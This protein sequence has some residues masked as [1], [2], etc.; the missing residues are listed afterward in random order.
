MTFSSWVWDSAGIDYY[1]FSRDVLFESFVESEEWNV[2]SFSWNR[3]E[4]LYKCCPIPYTLLH[5]HLVIKRKA[6]YYVTNLVVPTGIITLVAVIGFFSP[7]ASNGDRTEKVNLGITTLLAMSIQLLMISDKMPTTSDS[8]PLMEW[9]FLSIIVITSAGT[10]M[11]S[12]IIVIHQQYLYGKRV[13][14][15]VRNVF[16]RIIG[17]IVLVTPTKELEY[18]YRRY[19]TGVTDF[20]AAPL[21]PHKRSSIRSKKSLKLRLSR[22]GSW[23][24]EEELMRGGGE[25]ASP[26]N[27]PRSLRQSTVREWSG[28]TA[29]GD[30]LP[31][32]RKTASSVNLEARETIAMSAVAMGLAQELRG[33][34]DAIRNAICNED[35]QLIELEWSYLAVILDRILL[36]IFASTVSIIT[37]AMM[38]A[39]RIFY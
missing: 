23:E 2:V 37:L 33:S 32:Q 29:N 6:L 13:P 11:T 3:E 4:V 8:V 31:P 14:I 28:G 36:V 35:R 20:N 24:T 10:I 21:P 18:R 34:L 5:A 25:A 27:A 26:P 22:L 1:P 17:P 30:L 9:F 39:E 15:C 12:T 19:N 38:F 7:G 16:F